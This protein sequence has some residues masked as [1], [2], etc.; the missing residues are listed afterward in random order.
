MQMGLHHLMPLRPL[1]QVEFP[2]GPA[3]YLLWRGGTPVYAGCVTEAINIRDRILSHFILDESGQHTPVYATHF[4][5]EL[6]NDPLARLEQL[7]AATA[8]SAFDVS[9]IRSYDEAH[10]RRQAIGVVS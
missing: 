7:T 3:L 9:H 4:S 10:R 6:T 1:E 2:V 8:R 5:C